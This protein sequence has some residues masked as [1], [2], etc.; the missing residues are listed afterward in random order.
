MRKIY[1]M[2]TLFLLCT[3]SVAVAAPQ[4]GAP[5]MG[6]SL[7]PDFG[8]GGYDVQHYTLDITVAPKNFSLTGITTIEAKATEDLSRFNLDLVGL[9][10]DSI[11]VND[12]AATFTR[13][14]QELQI[15]PAQALTNGSMF[16]VEVHYNGIPSSYTSV[17]LPVLTGWVPYN[18]GPSCPCS[19]VLSEP[20]GAATFFPVNDHPLD[21]AT[22]TIKVTV[23]KPYNVATNGVQKVTDNGSTTTTVSEVTSP[24][25]SY[26]TTIDISQFDLVTDPGTKGGVPIR[27]FFEKNVNQATRDLFKT[28]DEMISY[29][30]S[31]FG[32]Y[33]F[34]VY[35]AL[36]L[37]IGPGGALEDQTLSIFG[38]DT[39]STDNDQS[40]VTIAHEL[41]HQWFGDSVSVGDWS[42]IWLNEGFATYAEGLWIEHTQG[43][44]ALKDWVKSNYTYVAGADLTPPGQAPADDLFNEGTYYRGGLTLAALRAKVGDTDFFNILKQWY[45]RHKGGNVRTAD[46][47]ALSNEISGQ[48][49]TQFFDAWLNEKP[50]PPIPELGLSN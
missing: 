39:V 27:N 45:Q 6:D 43:A 36:M 40:E 30:S 37:N 7:Y 44:D 9:T 35:G 49:L 23:P 48:D 21:K 20:D 29:F 12:A 8:N 5:G 11:T 22:Y 17:A 18:D 38:T 50:L 26:L 42:D 31:V 13:D 10:V 47:I 4:V 25:A 3:V 2:M 46:F 15:T 19:Y 41:S 32:P 16:T 1:W 14:G 28:Q 34:D 24:M 33:P